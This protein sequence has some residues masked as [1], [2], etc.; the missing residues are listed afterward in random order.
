MFRR[1]FMLHAAD[2][3][4]EGAADETQKQTTGDATG[5]NGG[6]A[7]PFAVYT[8]EAEFQAALDAKL[9]ERLARADEKAKSA[10][11]KA[12]EEAERK[13]MTDNSQFK[14]LSEKQAAQLAKLEAD[15]AKAQADLEALTGDAGK[16][17]SALEANV[18]E[19]RKG[20]PEHIIT[21]L[22]NLD[23]VQQLDWL[24]KSATLLGANVGIPATPKSEGKGGDIVTSFLQEQAERD[25]AR[26]NPLL[27]G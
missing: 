22:D 3:G 16:Y 26:R 25:K 5:T 23:P 21:L 17:R 11:Q 18:A 2:T 7:K 1:Y 4:T 8:T 15:Y 10:A 12:R 14:E 6:D 13:A 27:K 20:L 24:T 9:K 19:R